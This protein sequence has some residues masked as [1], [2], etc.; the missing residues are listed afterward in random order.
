ML[1]DETNDIQHIDYRVDVVVDVT[2]LSITQ[3]AHSLGMYISRRALLIKRLT[4]IQPSSNGTINDLQ[5]NWNNKIPYRVGSDQQWCAAAMRR[6]SQHVRTAP[7]RET[8]SIRSSHCI[9]VKRII[10]YQLTQVGKHSAARTWSRRST[11]K[12]FRCSNASTTVTWHSWHACMSA[13]QPIC[14]ARETTDEQQSNHA[15]VLNSIR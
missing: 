13:V 12:F 11:F 6:P 2:K 3:R 4:L 9:S 7:Q 5:H 14:G 8:Q 15:K 1:H 10:S